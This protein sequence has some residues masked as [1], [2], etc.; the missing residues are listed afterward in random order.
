MFTIVKETQ[1]KQLK[2]M[3]PTFV[4]QTVSTTSQHKQMP[5]EKLEERNT[6]LEKT[7]NH[8]KILKS[9]YSYRKK[10]AIKPPRALRM[11]SSETLTDP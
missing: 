9:Y 11:V 7:E 8:R 3:K 4:S 6:P 2:I 1:E 5:L 10:L